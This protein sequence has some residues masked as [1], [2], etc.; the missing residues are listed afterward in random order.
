[1]IKFYVVKDALSC[2][3]F[4]NLWE[5]YRHQEGLGETWFLAFDFA[6]EIDG[7]PDPKFEQSRRREH[8]KN[9]LLHTQW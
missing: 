8:P 3:N 2:W 9:F 6:R 7:S 5:I 1:V 4:S